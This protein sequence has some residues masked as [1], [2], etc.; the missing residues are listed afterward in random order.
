MTDVF[1]SYKNEDRARVRPLYDA[2]TAA[3][4]AVWWDQN[5]G[6]ATEWRRAI[7]DRLEAAKCVIVV[8]SERSVGEAGEWV[9]EEAE[10]AKRRHAYLPVRIDPVAA[11]FGF[12]QVQVLD[13]SDWRS[14]RND[15]RIEAVVAA[16]KAMVA[17]EPAPARP[18]IKP[19]RARR[20]WPVAVGGAAA[21]LGGLVAVPAVRMSLCGSLAL[22]CAATVERP[23][24]IA[25]LAFDNLI[26][27]PNKTYFTR[28][29]AEAVRDKLSH[30]DG[31]MVAGR[32]SSD[33]FADGSADPA[34]IGNTLGV[35]YVLEGSVRG[36]GDRLKIR[37]ELTDTATGLQSWSETFDHKSG[38]VFAVQTS[39][40]EHVAAALKV[41]MLGTTVRALKSEGTKVVA[42]YDEYL[43]GT[44]LVDLNGTM[45]QWQEAIACF[46]AAIRLDP[47]YSEAYAAKARALISY[48]NAFAGPEQLRSIFDSALA[49]A[50]RGVA[51]DPD[52]ATVQLALGSALFNG[53]LN[54]AEANPY[55]ERALATGGGNAD[56]LLSYAVFASRAGHHDRAAQTIARAVALDRLNPRV[57]KA[58]G[59]VMFAGRRYPQALAAFRQALVLNP[60]ATLVHAPI[61]R[62]L[63]QQ[64]LYPE[65]R[66]EFERETVDWARLTGLAIVCRQLGDTACATDARRKLW[67]LGASD[68]YQRAQVLAQWGEIAGALT[69]LEA[70]YAV[71]DTGV[72]DLQ[73]DPW[74]DPLRGEARF[75]ALLRRI[76][77]A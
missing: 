57:F 39:V 23:H 11:P 8:W 67:A 51:L 30:V 21:V 68:S 38:D 64:K 76:G 27:D 34:T 2:L 24:S 7:L 61:G 77:F 3:G 19:R 73:N 15:P 14:D 43:K 60:A 13:L 66:V 16:V 28:G 71:N 45:T 59:E 26:G 25:V 54:I 32:L 29:V 1:L 10:H 72:V 12:G 53:H 6:V 35:A 56:V 22:E 42:A 48:G 5:I 37:A 20:K 9:R 36:D 33:K 47:S 18:V 49:V 50:R 55:Y 63:A 74:L 17:A 31:M 52:V 62:I 65:A 40:A 75:K 58:Q 41:K 44:A 69:A 70:A 4:I 46:D